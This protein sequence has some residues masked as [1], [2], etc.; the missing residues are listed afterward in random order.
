ML[1]NNYGFSSLHVRNIPFGELNIK[2]DVT[3]PNGVCLS[4]TGNRRLEKYLRLYI[5]KVFESNQ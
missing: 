2:E 4:L 5:E 3:Q 1:K